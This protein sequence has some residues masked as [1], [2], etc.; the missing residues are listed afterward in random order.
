MFG[1]NDPYGGYTE[2]SDAGMVQAAYNRAVPC[3]GTLGGGCAG[4]PT[5][6][7]N[8]VATNYLP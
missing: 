6:Y 3:V 4:V 8:F 5:S 7:P 2:Y 1:T